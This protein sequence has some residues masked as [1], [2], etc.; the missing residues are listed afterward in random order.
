MPVSLI[1]QNDPNQNYSSPANLKYKPLGLTVAN[2]NTLTGQVN[3]KKTTIQKAT[4]YY[5][6][7]Q[8]KSMI[9]SPE[10]GQKPQFGQFFDNFKVKYLKIVIFSEK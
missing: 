6:Q 3:C 9:Q 5:V 7:N 8:E 2:K 4:Y 1:K 10:N